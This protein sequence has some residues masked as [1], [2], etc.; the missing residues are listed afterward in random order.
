MPFSNEPGCYGKIFIP[1]SFSGSE[2]LHALGH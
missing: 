2:L 1:Y